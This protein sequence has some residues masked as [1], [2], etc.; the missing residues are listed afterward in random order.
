MKNIKRNPI[1]IG[2]SI[3]AI[4]AANNVVSQEEIEITRPVLMEEIVVTAT[5]KADGAQVQ[6]VPLSINAYGEQQLEILQFR[7]LQSLSFTMPNVA[8]DDAGTARGVANFSFRG[9]GVNSTIPSIEPT[10]GVFVDGVYLGLNSGVVLDQFDLDSIEVLRGPQGLLFGR[11]VTG[12]AILLN[13]TDPTEDF[14]AKIKLTTE[15]GGEDLN[16]TLS[17]RVS[18]TLIDDT[19]LGKLAVYYNDNGG[20]LKNNF[21]G[22]SHG[23]AETS[24]I[25]G[26][27]TFFPSDSSELTVKVEAFAS[28]G[29]GPASKYYAPPAGSP[30]AGFAANSRSEDFEVNFDETGSYDQEST[31]VSVEYN[32][33]IGGGTLTNILGYRDLT[34]ETLGDI[35]GLPIHVFH[36]RAY[37]GHE[38]LSNELRYNIALGDLA[39]LTAGIYY[40]D[41]ELRYVEQRNTPSAIAAFGTA[42]AIGGG[43]T[44]STNWGAFT[45]IDWSLSESV[46]LSTGLRFTTEEKS[47]NAEL[48][49]YLRRNCNIDSG[50]CSNHAFSDQD[51]WDSV[52]PRL[53]LQWF[54]YDDMQFYG[55][56]SKGFRSGG[57]NL[58][59]TAADVAPGPFDQEEQDSIEI[60][61]KFQDPDGRVRINT[62]FFHNVISDMQREVNEASLDPTVPGGIV[63]I[64]SNTADVTIQGFELDM[65]AALT[66]SLVLGINFGY[67][68]GEYN[69]I[70]RDLDGSGAVDAGDFALELP[71]LAPY[72]YGVNLTYQGFIAGDYELTARAGYNHRDPAAYT[73]NNLGT[74]DSA[75]MI[76]ASIG[77]TTPSGDWTAILFGR[78]LKDEVTYGGDSRLSFGNF[79]PINRGRIYGAE[80]SYNF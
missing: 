11:N 24:I 26:G 43:D 65:T 52:T 7:D 68:D 55:V 6:E 27:L 5:K 29:D 23:A 72:T 59:N 57:F 36:S 49:S 16:N 46:V 47:A 12:G 15:A 25:R 45:N 19:L 80:L 18:G 42:L 39:D 10:V 58:R 74:F 76:D 17:G 44:E 9:L 77:L 28:E 34:S 33:D 30:L 71:R 14:T 32:L 69:T 67:V 20:W 75:D 4:L 22:G 38:Q 78:N 3:T 48:I 21:T 37:T 13:S 1:S 53:A 31:L 79:S 56:L 63:Q 70:L 8:M 41:S 40:Y 62:A 64:I 51:D 60:G 54:P 50:N 2:L 73:D 66:D 35:D 61:M